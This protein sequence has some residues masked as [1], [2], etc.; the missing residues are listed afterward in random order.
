MVCQSIVSFPDRFNETISNYTSQQKKK[1]IYRDPNPC[2]NVHPI[3]NKW[4][5][6]VNSENAETKRK[7]F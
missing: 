3:L 2:A 6:S 5:D 1:H 4:N 7:H